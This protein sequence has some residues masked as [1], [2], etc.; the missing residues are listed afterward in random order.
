M[1]VCRLPSGLIKASHTVLPLRRQRMKRVYFSLMGSPESEPVSQDHEQS[2]LT[3]L[4]PTH[5]TLPHTHT[6]THVSVRLSIC[7]FVN[8]SSFLGRPKAKMFNLF[9]LMGH[10]WLHHYKLPLN[11]KALLRPWEL[12]RSSGHGLTTFESA[13]LW[14]NMFY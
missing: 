6:T 13:D 3:S 12:L 7:L 1:W 11:R 14:E 10:C 8:C 5:P 4:M 2:S 9:P